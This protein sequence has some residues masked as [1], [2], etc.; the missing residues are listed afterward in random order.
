M[1][2]T[3]RN[4]F[5]ADNETA[6]ILLNLI[7][8]VDQ[9]SRYLSNQQRQAIS[10]KD[11]FERHHF[12]SYQAY[13]RYADDLLKQKVDQLLGKADSTSAAQ[14]DWQLG[15]NRTM[16]SE[17]QINESVDS[18]LHRDD[19]YDL[20]NREPQ[21]LGSGLLGKE[22]IDEDAKQPAQSI[23]VDYTD[24]VTGKVEQMSQRDL[25]NKK[26]YRE[27]RALSKLPNGM[28]P[29]KNLYEN[30]ILKEMLEPEVREN[31]TQELIEEYINMRLKGAMSNARF[32]EV[33]KTDDAHLF[34]K[35]LREECIVELG[36]N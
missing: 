16:P 6:Q 14:I 36:L 26:I 3:V 19:I 27:A 5:S 13:Q 22:F 24:P 20:S 25:M 1:R 17:H 34:I 29:A 21:T 33:M 15:K 10:V 28:E 8:H 32:A 11:Y 4:D 9:N 2:K 23:M 7:E 30:L 35:M 18:V 31:R 12:T